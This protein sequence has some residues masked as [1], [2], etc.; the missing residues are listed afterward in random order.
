MRLCVLAWMISISGSAYSSNYNLVYS[1]L[2]EDTVKID[3]VKKDKKKK[4]KKD[5]P[6]EAERTIKFNTDEGSWISLDVSPDGT[7]I[8]FELLGDLYTMPIAGGKATKLTK[9]LAFD[10]HP[11]YSPDGKQIVFVSDRSGGENIWVAELEEDT[12]IYKQITKGKFNLYQ[13][14]EWTPDGKYIVGSKGGALL[15]V[16]KLWIYHIDGGSGAQLTKGPDRLKTVEPAISPDGRYIW[17]SRRNGGWNYNAR[18]PQYQLSLYDRETGKTTT[19]TSRY[20]SAFTPT[21]SSDAKWL[22]YGT[23]HDEHTGLI[24]RNL[25]TGDEKWLAYPVQ[26]DEQESIATRDVLPGMSFTPD[27]Q[28][29]VTSYGGKIYNI[30]ISGGS[31]TEIPMDVDVEVELGPELDFKYPISDDAEFVARQIRDAVPSPDGT[32]LAFTILDR[33][34]IMDYPNGTPSRLS[35]MENTEANPVWSPKGNFIAF[36]TWSPEGGHI[37]KVNTTGRPKPVKLTSSPAI[38]Q[39]LAWSYNSNRIVYVKGSTQNYQDAVGPFAPGSF[40]ELGWISTNGGSTTFIDK[41]NGRGGPHFVKGNDRIYLYQGGREGKGLVSIRWD[42]SDEKAHLKVSGIKT[43][44]QKNASTAGIIK[45]APDGDQALAQVSNDIYVVTVPYVGGDTPKISVADPS[46]AE[47]P[48]RKITN[49][50]G[51]FPSW[52]KNSKKVHFSLGNAFFEYD[53]DDAK[54]YEDSVKQAKEEKKREEEKKKEEEEVQ[55]KDEDKDE[56]EEDGDQNEDEDEAEEE[57]S[58]KEDEDEEDKD[59]GYQPSEIRIKVN[60]KRDIPSGTTLLKGARIITMKGDEI[61]DN[62]DILVKNNRIEAIGPSGSL[63]IPS[64]TQEIDV[65]GKTI[66]PGFVD[67]HSHMWPA[68]GI[69]K[70]QIWMYAANLAYG[71]TT[72]RDPQ[73]ATTDVLTYS[74]HVRAGNMLGPRVYSTGPGVGFWANN[75]KDLDHA[76]KV[77]KQYSEYY[78]T[79]TIKMYLVGNRQQRQWVIMAAKEQKLMPTTE[80]ALDMKLDF[81]QILDGYPGHEHSFPIYPLYKDV[82]QFV[83]ESNTT[84]TPT[85]LV[86]YGGP[87]AENYYYATEDVHGDNKLNTFTPHREIDQKARR[88]GAWFMKE[89]HVF[90]DHAVFVK[91]LVAAGGYAGVGSH[92]QL[93]GLGYHWEL[94]NIQSGGLSEH[95]ALKVA[96]IH[97]AEAIGLDGDLGSLETGKLAD[98]IILDKNPLENIRNTNTVK[99]VMMNGRLYDG[100]TLDELAPTQKKADKFWWHSDEPVNIPGIRR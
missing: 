55:D 16:P 88:R 60:I 62:G 85:L 59:E 77:L 14:A 31:A 25:Q 36:V 5:L 41:T 24:L 34:Y 82:I 83:A 3:S 96:T 46:K 66:V 9:G 99:Y 4:K 7:T 47:F 39:Q 56:D 100:N 69:H 89:E 61:I 81:T 17:Y 20:G 49:F 44:G 95:D 18:F 84:Y 37:Y 53:L 40:A 42:G 11:R 63:T 15:G 78:D 2:Q 50:G 27:N 48:S 67:T 90:E 52:G 68:W 72:T 22:V 79:K 1:Y 93:Q 57:D 35:K 86:A 32:K 65:S 13:S 94:W 71:V 21:L 87:W 58:D 28:N 38:F 12:T 10:S 23:R 33:L 26:R 19:Q 64:R 76:R 30:P 51:H 29:L 98:L 73:T 54:V 92:G 6:L 70:N 97:G 74:D 8:V 80:G 43:F 75:I 91:D 45:M